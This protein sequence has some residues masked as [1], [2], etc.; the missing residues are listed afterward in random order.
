MG[1]GK[2]GWDDRI[3]DLDPGFRLSS[4]ETTQKVEIRDFLCH[5]S[6]LATESGDLLE[7]LGYSR[8]EILYRMRYLPLP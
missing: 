7:D 2:I 4:P 8:P 5:R 3:I 6:G 1:E